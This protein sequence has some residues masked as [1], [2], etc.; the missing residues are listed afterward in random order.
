[1]LDVKN[2]KFN[3]N[4]DDLLIAFHRSITA[5]E[6]DLTNYRIAKRKKFYGT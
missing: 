6:G 2:K 4:R 5:W 1:M 3:E